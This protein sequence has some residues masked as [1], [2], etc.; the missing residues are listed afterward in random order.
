MIPSRHRQR[1]FTLIELLVVIAIIGGLISIIVPSMS[2]ART[3]AKRLQCVNHLRGLFTAN[4]VYVDVYG[5]L[6]ELNNEPDEG[7]WQYNYI[8]FDGRDLGS[9]FGPLVK[10]GGFI[11]D[12][13]TLYC[14]TQRDP[15]HS[16]S[17]PENPWPVVPLLDTRSSYARR[18][19]LSGRS[20]S[21]LRGNPAFASDIFHLP[22]VIKSGHKTG[23]NAIY[24][25]GHVQWVKDPGILTDNE[26]LHPFQP[27]DNDIVEDIWDVLDNAG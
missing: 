13:E 16:F 21:R 22:K 23:V 24:I 17:T 20:L 26:L 4:S 14:P 1:A 27:E 12:I 5:R 3:K 15:Y 11:S 18:Y 2:K 10:D 25:D 8:I 19:H 6:P 9:N 7:S